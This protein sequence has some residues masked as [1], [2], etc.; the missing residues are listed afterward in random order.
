METQ[1]YTYKYPRPAVTT[2]CV[3]FGFDGHDLK[4][5]LIERGIEPFKGARWTRRPSKAP[6]VS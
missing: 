4:I 5:L 6:C 2:D 3:V 1:Q